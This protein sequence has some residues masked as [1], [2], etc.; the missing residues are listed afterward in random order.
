MTDAGEPP[1]I[2][3]PPIPTPIE[4]FVEPAVPRPG[5]GLPEAT[6]WMFLVF[7]LH[8][9]GGIAAILWIAFVEV[10]QTGSTATLRTLGNLNPAQWL[11]LAAGEQLVVTVLTLVLVAIRLGGRL[12]QPLN[13]SRPTLPHTVAVILLMFPLSVLCSELY[14]INQIGWKWLGTLIPA[15]QAFDELSS[16]EMVAKLAQGAGL[17]LLILVLAVG[18]AINEELIFRGLLGRGLTARWGWLPGVL[19]C[20]VMFG[21]VHM[22]PAH[23]LAVI[24]LGMA[25]HFLY[26]TT[27]SLWAPVLLHFLNNTWAATASKLAADGTFTQEQVDQPA[28]LLILLLAFLTA[29]SLGMVLWKSRIRYIE[30]DGTDWSPGFPTVEGPETGAA[31]RQMSQVSVRR[32]V[33]AGL[34]ATVFHAV[35]FA[36]DS[37][38][39]EPVQEQPAA[40]AE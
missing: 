10:T 19:M 36:T 26:I 3:T 33:V 5:P 34:V 13:L 11:M 24:P 20:S 7:G 22:H 14:R 9:I 23:V 6:G 12:S 15:L 39:Q 21:V 28:S 32:F 17:E 2:P 35:L 31:R 30:P 38:P 40:R 27:R 4:E 29:W 25:L 37:Q 16:V 18:P 1:A 8:L